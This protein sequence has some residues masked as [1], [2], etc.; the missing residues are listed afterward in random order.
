MFNVFAYGTLMFPEV[1]SVIAGIEC[2]G[3]PLTLPGYRRYEAT[4]RTWANFPVIVE[5]AGHSVDGLLFRDVTSQ[6]LA[7]LDWFEE[8]ESG[9]YERRSQTVNFDDQETKIHFYVCG[10][11]LKQMLMQPLARPW[12]PVLFGTHELNK[13]LRKVV[14]PAVK[15][16]P[17]EIHKSDGTQS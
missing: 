1:A 12:N 5:D 7:R 13:Y 2:T 8:T 9:L 17:F 3:E 4:I 6:Q 15:S 10:P 11:K 16:A 14:Y